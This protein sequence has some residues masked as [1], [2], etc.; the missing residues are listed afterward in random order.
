M[1]HIAIDARIINSSTGR[2][3]ERLLHY[4]EKIDTLNTYTV[5]VPTKD[6]NYWQPSNPN[7]KVKAADFDNYSFAEQIDFLHFL[8]NLAPDLTHFCMP[9]QPV[10]Y[11]RNH[12]TTVHD[13]NLL[14]T[15][16]SD[17]NWFVF[18]LKQLVGRFVFKRVAKSSS[19]IIT[20]THY[21]KDAFVKF[22]GISPK[23]VTV[24]HEAAEPPANSIAPYPVPFEKYILYVGQQA[25][26]KNIKRLA[27]AHQQ[28]LKTHPTVGLVLA[29][30][31]D[32]ASGKNQ[33]YFKAKGYT[34]IHFTDFVPDDQLNWLYENCNAY[35]FPSLM[36]GFGLPGLEAMVREA[37]VISSNATCLP[38]VYGDAAWYFD[39]LDTNDIANKIAEVLDNKPLRNGLVEK[40]KL[41]ANEYSWLKMAKQTHAIYMKALKEKHAN[42]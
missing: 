20:P 27:T 40:G 14:N 24:T 39:P 3:V 11:S 8:N 37:P 4:L 23:K 38:E 1:S 36:E 33:D 25:D 34:N 7:F 26:Y 28:L 5:L 41:K 29:G 16:N 21:V 15:Y 6:L 12:V 10:L 19:F 18:H 35:I 13:L 22:A 9:Q 17:K 30:K 2:Y 31:I 42:K 32:R